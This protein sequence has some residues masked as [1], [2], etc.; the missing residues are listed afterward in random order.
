MRTQKRRRGRKS[1][2]GGVRGGYLTAE[3]RVINQE[4]PFFGGHFYLGCIDG[5]AE[6]EAEEKV[7]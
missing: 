2:E 1:S 5:G 7:S 3:E 6:H 4:S